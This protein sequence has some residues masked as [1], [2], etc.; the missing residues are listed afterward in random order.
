M[1]FSS[2]LSVMKEGGKT[3]RKAWRDKGMWVHIKMPDTLTT[4][5]YLEV[6]SSHGLIPWANTHLDI[7]SEDWEIVNTWTDYLEED[8]LDELV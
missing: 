4:H 3:R 7:L 6:R 2:A 1:F 5:P 8:R